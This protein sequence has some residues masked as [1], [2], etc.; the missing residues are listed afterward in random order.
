MTSFIENN[1]GNKHRIVISGWYGDKNLGDEAQLAGIIKMIKGVSPTA[2]IIIF[3]DNPQQTIK[4]HKV[5]AIQRTGTRYWF[6]RFN[7]LYQSDLLILGGGTLLYD[8]SIGADQMVW[9]G[10]VITAKLAGTPTMYFNGGIGLLFNSVSKY[11]VK[12]VFN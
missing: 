6:K 10:D 12:H 9:L 4:E 7:E 3:S 2:E 11:C 1:M 8:T 5:K